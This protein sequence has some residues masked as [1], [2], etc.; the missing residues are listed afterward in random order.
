M[1][2]LSLRYRQIH[3]D[4]HTSPDIPGVG[5]AFDPEA[6]AATLERARVNSVTA[7]ARCHH[8]H[9]YYNSPTHPER[10]HPQ[11]VNKDLLA[12]QIEACH[13]RDIR[14]P[15]YTTVQWDDYTAKAHRDWICLD[16]QGREYDTAPLSP[17]FYRNLDVFHPGYRQFLKDHVKDLF[18]SVPAVDGLF[19]DIVS[20]RPSLAPHWLAAM[21]EAGLNPEDEA[22][23][24][25]FA[26]TVINEW[27]LEM[28]A[29]V[30]Q[31]SADCSIFYNAGHVGPR[32]RPTRDAYTHY[33]LESLPSGG[34]GYLH[35]PQT[36][37]YARNLG[38][39]TLGMTG[40]FHTS[41]GDFSSYK[42]EA[43]LQ[44]E[45][46]QMIALGA[47]CSVG[48]QLPPQGALDAATYDL[49]GSVYAEVEK[50][51][52]WC[53]GA[54]PV[55]DIGVL[56]PEEFVGRP[57]AF[58][59][60]GER[61]QSAAMG[62]VR[63][64]TELGHQFDLIDSEMDFAAYPVLI[65]P[66]AIPVDDALAAK[67]DAYVKGG[68]ALLATH[69]SGLSPEADRFA[70]DALGV[71][72][73]GPAPFSP[74]FIVPGDAL[75]KGMRPAPH[76]MYLK[77][78]QV[79]AAPGAEVLAEVQVPYFNRTWRH[80]CSHAHTPSSGE[81]AGYPGAVRNGNCVWFMHPVFEQYQRNAPLWCKR[82]VGNA[83]DLLLPE[84]RV[85]T[86]G[87][88]TLITSLNRQAEA[89]RYVLHLLHYVPERRGQ[90]FDTI[91][92][93][94][95]VY[96]IEVSVRVDEPVTAV[97]LE[98]GGEA[99][100]FEQSEGRVTFTVPQ[101]NGHALIALAC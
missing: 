17:G 47:K 26:T 99:L 30:R 15:I 3:L 6:F 12:Q 5:A 42:N 71:S 56:T 94:L 82:L 64:L 92:E 23:R 31:F 101:V 44:F 16:A 50:K 28:T 49:I 75:G 87:P 20:P 91:E 32:H 35:F 98:P 86:N 41:W 95:P 70:L 60:Q 77:G 84:P 74:D 90:A 80:F 57:N 40:K 52:P 13:K 76:V 9:L 25:R 36:Q 51:E 38:L 19:F 55:A 54:R 53:E 59:A 7:F 10:I 79:E 96:H 72:L 18:A 11:L 81:T 1:P 48:D 14:V 89:S 85:T 22:D 83:L 78:L 46:F 88:S 68:G 37:R 66:D 24:Q 29:F 8:G 63:I 100:P 93:V 65:L 2:P 73:V 97:T 39:D 21:D 67:L 34:W 58:N 45:C 61:D 62:A 33:E 4:F 69:R 27:K 43:A